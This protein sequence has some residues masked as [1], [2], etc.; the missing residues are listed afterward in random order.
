MHNLYRHTVGLDTIQRLGERSCAVETWCY[1]KVLNQ[2][3]ST[4]DFKKK[5]KHTYALTVC[6]IARTHMHTR[7]HTYAYT[8]LTAI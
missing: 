7:K 1:Q 6:H 4:L 8:I 3:Y 5:K 2:G